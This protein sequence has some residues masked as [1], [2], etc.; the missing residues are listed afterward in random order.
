MYDYC[1]GMFKFHF[2]K[3]CLLN[4]ELV[5]VLIGQNIDRCFWGAGI[6][7]STFSC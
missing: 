3:N 6:I 5:E 7:P 4:L 1:K 2:E